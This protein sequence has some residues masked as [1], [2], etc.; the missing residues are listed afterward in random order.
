[1]ED[2]QVVVSPASAASEWLD[3]LEDGG[4]PVSFDFQVVA[5]LEVQPFLISL[6]S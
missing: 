6:L 1:V 2:G 4:E 5:A 3:L